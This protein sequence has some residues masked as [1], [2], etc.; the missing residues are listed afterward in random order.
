MAFYAWSEIRNGGEFEEIKLA[1]GATRR[2]ITKRKI[3]EPGAKITKANSGLTGEEWDRMLE[4]GVIRDYPFPEGTNEWTSPSQAFMKQFAV[5]GEIP[6]D[7][8]LEMG[9]ATS[10]EEGGE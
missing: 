2:V 9:M 8:L 3:I 1:T 6:V 4:N 5:G 10:A 7:R